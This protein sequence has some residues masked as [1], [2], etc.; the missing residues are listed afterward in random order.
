MFSSICDRTREVVAATTDWGESGRR[1]G[2]YR[3]DLDVDDVCVAPLLAAGYSVL[4]EESGVQHPAAGPSTL[5][6]VVV[7]PLDGSTN[8]SLGLPWCAT[9]LCLVVDGAAEV[10][11]IA[12]LATGA[13]YTAVRDGGARLDGEAMTVGATVELADAVVAI[14]GLPDRHYGWRQ[15]RAMGASAL[16]ICAVA[17]GAFDGY[18]DMSPDAHGVWDYVGA[19]LVVQEAGGVIVDAFGRDLVVLDPDARR[20]P[21]AA[22]GTALLDELLRHRA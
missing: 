11:T 2:Q 5:G 14:S 16:D 4:S 17:G 1:A 10:A 8:A 7:D 18:V 13:R 12:N 19:M 22:T 6:T 20:T 21:V 15:F 9:S 3:V